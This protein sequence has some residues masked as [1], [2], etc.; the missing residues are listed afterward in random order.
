MDLRLGQRALA[1]SNS[2]APQVEGVLGELEGE[3]RALPLLVLRR[4]R[5]HVVGEAGG[6]GH[7]RRRS[8]PRTRGPRTPRAIARLSARRVHGV[9]ALDDHRPE[10]VGVVGE[11]LVGDHVARH[12]AGDEPVAGDRRGPRAASLAG[13]RTSG[14]ERGCAGSCRPARRSCRSAARPA[15]RGSCSASSAAPSGCRGPRRSTRRRRPCRSRR[16]P[17]A[18]S[19]SGTPP[20][21]HVVGDVDPREGGLDSSSMPTLAL[22]ASQLGVDA[23]PPRRGRASSAA[24]RQ[25]VAARARTA[26]GCRPA[27]RSRCAAGRSRS[28]CGPG[29]WRSP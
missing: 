18:R 15:S 7:A 29:R 19:S 4:R 22:S 21:S 3:E 9:A 13:A 26:G 14:A 6:L 8:R 1:G 5:Q 12:E 11:D 27:R 2:G 16:P 23:G 25:R 24:S 17:R 20:R 10:P 28:A